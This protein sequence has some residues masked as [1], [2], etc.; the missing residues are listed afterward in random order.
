M[1]S[2]LLKTDCIHNI[3][4]K[5]TFEQLSEDEKNYIY[6]LSKACW[7]G[8]PIVLFQTSYE[9]PA[10]F[11]IFQ[12]FFS[13][14]KEFSE[15]KTILLKNNISD[16][17]YSH[18]LNYVANFYSNFGNYHLKKKI[19]PN[20]ELT[21]FEAILKLSPSFNDIHSIWDIIKYIIYDS[22]ENSIYINLEE[23]NI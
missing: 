17:N 8:Q 13:S 7:A 15:I 14:F 22:S 19:I 5:E 21:D 3:N 20:I 16:I 11:I 9:S 6:F 12:I 4:F 2:P 18:F 23:K 10:L 1:N